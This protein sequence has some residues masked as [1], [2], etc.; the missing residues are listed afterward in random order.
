MV[1]KV[2]KGEGEVASLV[3]ERFAASRH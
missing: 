2:G 3:G 1:Y